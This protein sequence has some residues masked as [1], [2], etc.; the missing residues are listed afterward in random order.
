MLRDAVRFRVHVVCEVMGLRA[1]RYQ[2]MRVYLYRVSVAN[3]QLM[4]EMKLHVIVA[5]Q[6]RHDDVE[7][8]RFLEVANPPVHK[9]R[10]DLEASS[11]DV[12][13]VANRRKRSRRLLPY[14]DTRIRTS[15]VDHYRS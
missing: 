4:H 5:V 11:G 9:A 6:A 12:S 7:S 2:L 10:N 3:D 13:P 14:Q 15:S 8:V 1:N